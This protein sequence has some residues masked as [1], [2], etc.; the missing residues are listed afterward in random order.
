VI[1]RFALGKSKQLLITL[2]MDATCRFLFVYGTL[3]KGSNHPM[4]AFLAR[5]ATF[6]AEGRTRGRLLDLGT[7]PGMVEPVSPD[8]WV[9]GDVFEL[10]D[11]ESIL[12]ALNRYEGCDRPNPLYE[13]RQTPIV[14]STG[15]EL[16]AYYYHRCA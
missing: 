7:Y 13:R 5:N 15:I 4:A 11:P 16:T 3:R 2:I 14:L 12:P 10:T 9:E 6:V 8:D 1:Y